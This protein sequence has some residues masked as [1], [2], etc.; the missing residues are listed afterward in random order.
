MVKRYKYF[1]FFFLFLVL[2]FLPRYLAHSQYDALEDEIL[3]IDNNM[4]YSASEQLLAPDFTHPPLW[5]LLMEYPTKLLALEHGIGYYRSIQVLILFFGLVFSTGY[6]WRK[7]PHKFI[8]IFLLLFLTNVELIHLTSQHRMYSL[9]LSFGVFYALYWFYLIKYKKDKKWQDFFT[10]GII[11][12]LGFFTN[13]SMIWLIPIFPIAYLISSESEILK[14]RIKNLFIFTITFFVSISWFIPTFIK[15]SLISINANQWTFDFNIYNVFQLFVNYFGIIP[16]QKDLGKISIY[17]VVFIVI[18]VLIVLGQL[19]LNKENS[20]KRIFFTSAISFIFFLL[21]VFITGN[22]LLYPRTAICLVLAFYVLITCAFGSFKYSRVL[23]FLIAMLQLSQFLLY[24]NQDD[25][26]SNGY[27]FM[28][29]RIHP[30]HYFVDYNF[31]QKSCLVVIPVWNYRATKYFL[32]DVVQVKSAS[33]FEVED[34]I[35]FSKTKDCAS[36]YFLEQFSIGESRLKQQYKK[37]LPFDI[38]RV[39]LDE[40]ENQKLYLM[41]D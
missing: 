33:I 11:A 9:V 18:L 37:F 1:F 35:K 30:I 12:S 7:I 36:F 13:Y 15:N 31:P 34:S 20:I 22:S 24:F 39:L 5:Y 10:V 32:E 38:E 28:D 14:L 2:F 25:S 21:T 6:F 26:F 3:A 29:Y 8:L 41:S 19:F 4:I 16:V 40:H 17:A 27:F 23:V